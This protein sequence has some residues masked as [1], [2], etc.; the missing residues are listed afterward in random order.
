MTAPSTLPALDE[1]TGKRVNL[2]FVPKGETDAV[3]QEGRIEIGSAVGL[4]FKEKGKSNVQLVE[5]DSIQAVEEL[6]AKEPNVTVKTL[7]PIPLGRIR[8]HLADRH[9]YTREA[10]NGLTEAQA[11]AEHDAVDHSVLAHKHEE[12]K[13]AAE[14]G[15]AEASEADAA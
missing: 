9:G 2:T 13:A 5:A 10:V 6:A 12:P 11:Q 8:Q 7:Q 3:T 14:A 1:L 4:M 15:A